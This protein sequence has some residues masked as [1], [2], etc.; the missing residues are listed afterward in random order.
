MLLV[1]LDLFT[2]GCI[3][4]SLLFFSSSNSGGGC[5]WL[6]AAR[7]QSSSFGA[8]PTKESLAEIKGAANIGC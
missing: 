6:I 4:I 2:V 5:A 3:A 1:S 7:R 8:H